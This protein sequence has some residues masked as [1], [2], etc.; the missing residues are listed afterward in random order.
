MKCP[1]KNFE[2]C[3]VEKCPSCNYEEVKHITHA[4]RKPVYMSDEEALKIGCLWEETKTEYKFI[5]CKLVEN[6]TQPV[7][8]NNT[9]INNTSNTRVVVNK[10]IF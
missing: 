7:L 1:Y 3:I 10:S 5:S 8:R 9:E 4:G 2:E 6:G